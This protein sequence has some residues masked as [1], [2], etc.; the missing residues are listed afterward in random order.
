M[1]IRDSLNTAQPELPQET[2]RT[3]CLTAAVTLTRRAGITWTSKYGSVIA[4]GYDIGTC[5]GMNEKG[6]VAS[7]LFLPESVYHRPGAVS[8][9]H[10]TVTNNK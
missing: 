5:D 4:A 10:L 9:T 7:L 6:L 3:T 2:M 1:C 8:Y